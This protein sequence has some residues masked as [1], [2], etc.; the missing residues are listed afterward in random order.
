MVQC[1]VSVYDRDIEPTMGECLVLA[2]LVILFLIIQQAYHRLPYVRFA[3]C[4]FVLTL[5]RLT[6]M[7]CVI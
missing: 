7:F 6:S 1:W 5:N 4:S 3:L 2:E